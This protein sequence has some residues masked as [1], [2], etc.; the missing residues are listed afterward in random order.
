MAPPGNPFAVTTDVVVL[1]VRDR[2]QRVLVVR[3]ANEPFLG[4]FA[5]P[6]G[7]VDAEEDLPEAALR[8]L[9]EETG[10]ELA[11]DRLEQLGAYGTPGRDPRGPTVTVAFLVADDDLP[12]PVAGSDAAEASLVPVEDLLADPEALAFDHGRILVDAVRRAQSGLE[13][14]PDY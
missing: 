9:A 14:R 6:G 12:D 5:F 1:T 3:R 10:I 13:R 2:K 4:R 7:Y 11:A 8:E